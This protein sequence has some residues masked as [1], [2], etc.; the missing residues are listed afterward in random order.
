MTECP[1]EIICTAENNTKMTKL[2]SGL[3]AG[4]NSGLS[5]SFGPTEHFSLSLFL[6][7]FP[8]RLVFLFQV[9]NYSIPAHLPFTYSLQNCSERIVKTQIFVS[10]VDVGKMSR[11]VP[12]KSNL[13]TSLADERKGRS[14]ASKGRGLKRKRKRREAL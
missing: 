6:L 12:K 8:P 14:K 4:W 13:R 11:I 9:A 10:L 1:A 3:L 2:N 7:S 5:T